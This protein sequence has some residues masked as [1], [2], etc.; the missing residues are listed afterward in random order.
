MTSDDL[1]AWQVHMDY[2]QAQAAEALGVEPRTYRDWLA[3]TSRTSGKPIAID[4]RTALACSA[5]AAGL[6]PYPAPVSRS[7][8]GAAD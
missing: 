2:T 1:R 3:G 6:A 5:I 8:R 4:R 7:R